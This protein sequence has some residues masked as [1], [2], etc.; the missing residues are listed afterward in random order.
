MAEQEGGEQQGV[1]ERGDP[2]STGSF[3]W[4]CVSVCEMEKAVRWGV[5]RGMQSPNGPVVQK[6]KKKTRQTYITSLHLEK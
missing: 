3:T 5:V 6:V 2:T 1:E 4:R